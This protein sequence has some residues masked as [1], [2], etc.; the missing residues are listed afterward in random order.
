MQRIVIRIFTV[1]KI[2]LYVRLESFNAMDFKY[3]KQVFFDCVTV[4]VC[5]RLEEKQENHQR[6]FMVFE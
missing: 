2:F 1:H 5:V 6:Q 3:T 4:C